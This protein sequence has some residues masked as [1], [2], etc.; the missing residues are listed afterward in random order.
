MA[1]DSSIFPSSFC[2]FSSALYTKNTY[3]KVAKQ[4]MYFFGSK[5]VEQKRNFARKVLK[6][7]YRSVERTC[8]RC[9]WRD[10]DNKW[11]HDKTYVS[12]TNVCVS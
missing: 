2:A 12:C 7:M 3:M 9:N 5:R 11:P 10:A 6:K 4:K 8:E 1:D